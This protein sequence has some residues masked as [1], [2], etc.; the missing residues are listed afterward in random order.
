MAVGRIIRKDISESRRVAALKT[1]SARLLY[2]WLI[3]HADVNGNF[4]A[5]PHVVNGRVLTRLSKTAEEVQ[6]YLDD[7]ESTGLI[8]RYEADGDMYLHIRKFAEKQPCLNPKR[9]AKPRIPLP[10][11]DEGE[12]NSRPTPDKLQTNSRQ[13]PDKLQTNSRPT[14]DQLQTNSRP[15]QAQIKIK[16]KSKIKTKDP[17]PY[18]PPL[19]RDKRRHLEHV[20]LTDDEYD[21]LCARLGETAARDYIERLNDY[22]GSRGC[23]YKSHYH[24]ILTWWRNDNPNGNQRGTISGAQRA[25]SAAASGGRP[26]I[27]QQDF[28]DLPSVARA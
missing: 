27:N 8:M 11:T 19:H 22:I 1:D 4:S 9:E 16:S 13:T 15:A 12:T 6:D 17:P 25:A 23:R 2:T 14:P 24:T 20:F 28:G 21:K 10:A 18:T 5:D 3:A 7:L 26:R